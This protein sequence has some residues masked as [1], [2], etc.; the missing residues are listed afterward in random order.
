MKSENWILDEK[1]M[2]G[3][4]SSE[5]LFEG[6]NGVGILDYRVRIF[7]GAI[8]MEFELQKCAIF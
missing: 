4:L 8:G 1:Q 5:D 2:E 7:S 3:Q 6:Q